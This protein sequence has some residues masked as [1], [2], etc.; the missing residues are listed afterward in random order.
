MREPSDI[1]ILF[2]DDEPDLLSSLGRFLR[3]EPYR[4]LFALSGKDALVTLLTQPVD[5]VISD[6]RMPEMD[7][8]TLLRGIKSD[9]PDIIRIILSATRDVEQT[10]DAINTGEVY[11][12]ISKPIAPQSFKQIIGEVVDYCLLQSE[13]RETMSEI[14]KRL[15][16]ASPPKS[17]AGATISAM[18]IP[19]GHLGGDFA[20]YFVY[21]DWHMDILIGDVMGK[22]IRSAL[23]AASLKQLFAKCLALHDCKITPKV[24]CPYHNYDIGKIDQVLLKVE[25]MCLESL[26]ALEVF[27]TLN[28]TRF[29]FE[30][31]K[32]SLVDCGHPSVIHFQCESHRC[33]FL[34]G[35]NLPLGLIE[36]PVYYVLT[37][38]IKPGDMLLFYSDGITETQSE[39]GEL[40]GED[41]L[42]ALV[43]THAH[44]APEELL[45]V[46]RAQ[47]AAFGGID[48]FRDDFTCIVVR[49]EERGDGKIGPP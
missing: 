28:Y 21:D 37:T 12:F 25:A 43:Q 34:R 40:F 14:E 22:G 20:D 42:S 47:A 13:R 31:G 16:Q 33:R 29:D 39:S 24:A 49:I 2:V 45:E 41:R 3:R 30:C 7:G 48:R 4:L 36:Q 19:A 38:D 6:L 46:I 26:L 1:T 5:I 10:I 32:M 9:Y 11:R 44:L 27:A 15:L 35:D 17:L 18:M 23:V 8:L